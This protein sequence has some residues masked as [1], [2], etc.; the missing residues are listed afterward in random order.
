MLQERLGLWPRLGVPSCHC[1][2][3]RFSI[4][5]LVHPCV[6]PSWF[7]MKDLFI[8]SSLP[9]LPSFFFFCFCHLSYFLKFQDDNIAFLPLFSPSKP[10][11]AHPPLALKSMASFFTSC[12]CIHSYICI[13]LY[14]PKYNLFSPYNVTCMRVFRTELLALDNRLVCSSLGRIIS[15]APS[16]PQSP[17]VLCV[18]RSLT[19]VS[20]SSLVYLSWPFLFSSCS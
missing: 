17:T 18:N 5:T 7:S 16:F 19:G 13:F 20:P 6:C 10:S 15:S 2:R 14:I 12:Y 9:L 1:S 4:L 11:H 3:G 8:F